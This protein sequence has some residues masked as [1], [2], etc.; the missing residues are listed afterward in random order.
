[1]EKKHYIQP[2]VE[3]LPMQSENIMIPS[4]PGTPYEPAPK[5]RWKI[6]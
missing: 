2:D 4:S 6:F 5:K 1:M 3:T